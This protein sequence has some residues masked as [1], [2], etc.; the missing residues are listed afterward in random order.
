[1]SKSDHR[2]GAMPVRALRHGMIGGRT[3]SA[4]ECRAVFCAYPRIQPARRYSRVRLPHAG[5]AATLSICGTKTGQT[6]MRRQTDMHNGLVTLMLRRPV[7]RQ[8]NGKADWVFSDIF[9][10]DRGVVFLNVLRFNG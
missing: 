3:G 8:F 9:R 4:G 6:G 2:R 7:F 5:P 10:Y 1:M